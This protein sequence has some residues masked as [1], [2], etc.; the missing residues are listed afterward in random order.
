MSTTPTFRW[1]RRER[2]CSMFTRPI[3]S[4][5]SISSEDF[6]LNQYPSEEAM[7]PFVFHTPYGLWVEGVVCSFELSIVGWFCRINSMCFPPA[8]DL[9]QLHVLDKIPKVY[10]FCHLLS[11]SLRALLKCSK[12]KTP[13][14][15][16]S[17]GFCTFAH[18]TRQC[19]P[20][21]ASD[22][23]QRMPLLILSTFLSN[24][25]AG[26]KTVRK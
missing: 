14:P 26:A 11:W 6:A 7:F 17:L 8:S 20:L 12:S 15:R 13:G 24:H 19:P 9:I 3:S 1:S 10:Q 2:R 21:T 18:R 4:N 25:F 5:K 23:F 22:P 16:N